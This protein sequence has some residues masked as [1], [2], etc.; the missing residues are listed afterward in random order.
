[1][2]GFWRVYNTLQSTG[3]QTDVM[4]PLIELPDRK[5][6]I[7]LAVSSDGD[8]TVSGARPNAIASQLSHAPHLRSRSH[9]R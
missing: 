4:K 8:S 7:K 1:M 9:Q 2:W 6:K 3:F 5:G